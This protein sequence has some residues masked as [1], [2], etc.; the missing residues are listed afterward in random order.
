MSKPKQKLNRIIDVDGISVS[1]FFAKP[2]VSNSAIRVLVACEY[3]GIVRDAFCQRGFDAWSCDVLDTESPGNHIKGNVLDILN[4][5]WDLMIA[6]PPCTYLTYAGMANWYDK[7]RAEKRIKAAAFFMSLYNSPIE[8]V[9]IENPQGIMSKIFREPDMKFHPYYFGE[10]E[11]KRTC[12]WLKN[13]PVLEYHL[14][15][16]LFGKKT[17]VD[18]PEPTLIDKN[19]GKRYFTDSIRNKKQGLMRSK[20]FQ[21][22]ANAMASQWGDYLLRSVQKHCC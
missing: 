7:G 5:D 4:D 16:N 11:M 10:R 8:R 6:F 18:K 20:T 22:V 9:C 1:P 19:G 3:S 21:S 15:D 12:L 14:E 13:L 17:S 2:H